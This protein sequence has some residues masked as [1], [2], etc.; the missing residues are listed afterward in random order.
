MYHVPIALCKTRK[1]EYRFQHVFFLQM[2]RIQ[3][4]QVIQKVYLNY[5]HCFF[6][7]P[8][9]YLMLQYS[10]NGCYHRLSFTYAFLNLFT[11]SQFFYHLLFL[12]TKPGYSCPVHHILCVLHL[13]V[14]LE[15]WLCGALSKYTEAIKLP[16][17]RA[18]SE[19]R[20][21]TWVFNI[22]P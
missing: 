20:S 16:F 9:S 4:W 1:S 17:K 6:S 7:L 19:G 12:A 2:E 21:Q 13:S 11:K 18:H 8:A 10:T 3:D 22:L 15:W 14:K 5:K